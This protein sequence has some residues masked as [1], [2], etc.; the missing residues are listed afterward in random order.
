[1][2]TVTV[3]VNTSQPA[4]TVDTKKQPTVTAVGIQGAR[5][6]SGDSVTKLENLSNVDGADL[7]NGSVLVYK[8]STQKWL[9]TRTLEEQNLEGGHY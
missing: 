8:T 4:V 3:N 5:G 7:Q 6:P 2:P 1:M 9:A